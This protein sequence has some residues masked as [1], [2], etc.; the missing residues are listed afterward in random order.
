MKTLWCCVS[1]EEK[2]ETLQQVDKS[3]ISTK[4]KNPKADS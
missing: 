2:H 4:K 3:H 1:G